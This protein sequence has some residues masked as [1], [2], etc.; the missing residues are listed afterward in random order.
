MKTFISIC[1]LSSLFAGYSSGSKLPSDV[2]QLLSNRNDAVARIDEIF[3]KE[4]EKLKVKYAKMGDLES[5][6]KTVNLIEKY[7]KETLKTRPK[8]EDELIG[9]WLVSSSTGWSREFHFMPNGKLNGGEWSIV[10]NGK[11]LVCKWPRG[12][13][14][15]FDLP[16]VDSVLSGISP[17]GKKLTATKVK[18]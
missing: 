7:S 9:R 3:V 13:A 16:P 15:T 11:K 2:K 12:E 5:A 18:E 1:F 17:A 4:L 8:I 14:D 6:N 10:N